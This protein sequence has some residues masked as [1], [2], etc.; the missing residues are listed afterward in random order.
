MTKHNRGISPVVSDL[1]LA[2]IVVAAFAIVYA[3]ST[4]ITT[5]MYNYFTDTFNRISEDLIIEEAYIKT[6][7][8]TVTLYVRNIGEVTSKITSIYCNG[9]LIKKVQGELVVKKNQLTIIKIVL[10]QNP[11]K[12]APQKITIITSLG[13]KFTYIL[14]TQ[15]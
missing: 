2:T 13:S 14:V 7:N 5:Q 11:A 3:T 10:P 12:F 1:L 6:G 8:K 4:G 9:T 15:P